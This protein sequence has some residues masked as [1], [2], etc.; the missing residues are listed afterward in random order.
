MTKIF[1]IRHGQTKWN[2]LGRYQGQSD[3]ELSEL[4]LEQAKLLAAG[5]PETNISAV[6]ASDLQRAY[7][8]AAC[9]ADVFGLKVQ[10][11]KGLREI[12]FGDWE[13][14]T[15]KEIAASWPDAGKTFFSNPEKTVI[16]AGE[17]FAA[18]QERGMA[19]LQ[20]IVKAH[21]G[22]N[23]VVAAHGAIIRTILAE[24]LHMPLQYLWSIR[25]DNTAINIIQ[26]D[27]EHRLV[28]L[29]NSTAHLKNAC[30]KK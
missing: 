5:F 25:Q 1:L 30:V 17:S 27:D 23:V 11:R 19:S 16:P 18:V 4:G 15:Y 7:H 26:Y 3:I 13:G 10:A 22:E 24:A 29:L 2:V 20:E 21:P 14:K 12:D 9:V 8:T 6:Y 28:E